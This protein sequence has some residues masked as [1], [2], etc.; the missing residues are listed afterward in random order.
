LQG[1]LINKYPSTSPVLPRGTFS[2]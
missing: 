1:N 2:R